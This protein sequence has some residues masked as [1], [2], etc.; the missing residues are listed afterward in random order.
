MSDKEKRDLDK[1]RLEA[2]CVEEEDSTYVV[3]TIGRNSVSK[4]EWLANGYIGVWGKHVDR[5][6]GDGDCVHSHPTQR[7]YPPNRVVWIDRV[8]EGGY[9]R[10]CGMRKVDR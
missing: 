8:A 5:R 10:C 1:F 3:H 9:H 2:I 4:I 6:R 7:S